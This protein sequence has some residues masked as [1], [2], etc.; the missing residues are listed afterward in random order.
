MKFL[1]GQNAA[2]LQ[3]FSKDRFRRAGRRGGTGRFCPT[4]RQTEYCRSFEGF[5][6]A[7]KLIV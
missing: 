7:R 3:H 6:P 5:F 1:Q 4:T 2:I